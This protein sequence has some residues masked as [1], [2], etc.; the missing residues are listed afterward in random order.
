MKH[1]AERAPIWV[2]A[3]MG[4]LALGA[5]LGTI[6]VRSESRPPDETTRIALIPERPRDHPKLDDT[7]PIP[8]PALQ[9]PPRVEEDP[10]DF[11]PP[12]D[13]GPDRVDPNAP[14]LLSDD[15]GGTP[16][17]AAAPDAGMRGDPGIG[18]GAL[19]DQSGSRPGPAP[20]RGGRPGRI[21][22]RIARSQP[23][24]PKVEPLLAGGLRWLREHQSE[25]GM[26]DCD[27]FALRCDPKRGA[28][29]TGGGSS[30]FDVGVTGLALLAFLGAGCD[31]NGQTPND[32][33]VRKGLRWLRNSQDAEGCFGPRGD[34]RFTYSHACATIAMCE[35]AAFNRNP[36]WRKSAQAAVQFIETSQNPR[37]GWRYGVRPGESDVSVTGC[38]LLALKAAKDA[39]LV[40]SE[41]A[42]RDGLR[43]LDS[44][45]DPA[46]GRTGYLKP[47]ELPV[48]PD[49]FVNRWPA[50]ESEALTAI[51]IC[52]RILA[53][54]SRRPAPSSSRRRRRCGTT[55]AA[56]S[57]C[58]TGTT[59]RSRCTSSAARGGSAGTRTSRARSSR[60]RSRRA[61]PREASTRRIPGAPKEAASTPPRS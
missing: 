36:V 45:T 39:G 30:S 10:F 5:V 7:I 57:T 61:V 23:F 37:K 16:D 50:D 48:R 14:P 55:C 32:E 28:A 33:V 40:V 38:M 47:D 12:A 54:L 26:W 21:N 18:P 15:S 51:A 27:G 22:T 6:Y 58:T 31:G 60:T 41:R 25:D 29:C 19:G 52:S 20:G 49:G 35:A 46:T 59:A 44:V 24:M 34:V 53:T 43:F 56:R 2:I 8:R 1:A 17:A 3:V 9:G 42:V 13:P 11:V 4:H